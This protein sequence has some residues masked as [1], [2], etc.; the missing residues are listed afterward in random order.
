MPGFY[1]SVSIGLRGSTSRS[2]RSRKRRSLS[3]PTSSSARV[4]P[5]GLFGRPESAQKIGARSMQQVMV[6]EL[7]ARRQGIQQRQSLSRSIHHRYRHSAIQR[8]NWRGLNALEQVIQTHNPGPIGVRGAR[9]WQCTAAIAA[10]SANGPAHRASFRRRAAGLRNVCAIP[11]TTVLLVQQHD[12]AGGRRDGPRVRASEGASRAAP[13]WL[14]GGWEPST[15]EIS[16]RQAN[17]FGAQFGSHERAR[18]AYPS[19]NTR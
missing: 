16:P 12:V 3:L 11:P 8:D 10:C 15:P 19:L 17:R 7:A 9:A 4:A 1:G 6:I 2:R 18:V 5:C 13:R 14:W